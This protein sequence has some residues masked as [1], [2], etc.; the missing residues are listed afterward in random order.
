MK[1]VIACVSLAWLVAGC[2]DWGTSSDLGQTTGD[3]G[4]SAIQDMT[5]PGVET[6]DA[7]TP[8]SVPEAAEPLQEIVGPG[9]DEVEVD[10]CPPTCAGKQCGDDGCGGLCGT[11]DDPTKPICSLD[12]TACIAQSG[13]FPT[14]WSD[15]GVVAT[16][17]TPGDV[18]G[19]AKCF[20]YSGDGKGDNG[21][22][23]LATTINPEIAKAALGELGILEFQGVTD[24]ANTPAFTLALLL[25]KAVPG[26][27]GAYQID[28]ASFD[29][30]ALS[31]EYPPLYA[32]QGATIVS[33]ALLAEASEIDVPYQVKSLGLW[34]TFPLR[35]VRLTATIPTGGLAG[36]SG[37]LGFYVTKADID[38]NLA[39]LEAACAASTAY[40]PE[41]HAPIGEKPILP[42]LIDMDLD[43][44]GK[45]DAM[46]V[47]FEFTLVA[48]TIAGI[49]EP[50]ATP[51]D[52]DVAE[53]LADASLDV[54]DGS[55]WDA[56]GM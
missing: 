46:S 30:T 6:S 43:G 42:L 53:A 33:G 38:K 7:D 14:T 9:P 34:M 5:D 45:K 18:T 11:C 25:A 56:M 55:G 20:D 37:V 31:G 32:F 35:D 22:R 3:T 51:D 21:P 54:V 41:C 1:Y 16:L 27:E 17:A 12:Q 15:I 13:T 29:L 39:S 49:E 4:D 24:F 8:E 48:G 47:C 10:A 36:T 50:S 2:G 19:V 52:A 40:P 28:P 26:G 23:A 44:D